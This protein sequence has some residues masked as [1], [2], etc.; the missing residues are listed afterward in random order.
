MKQ[1]TLQ[2]L[3]SAVLYVQKS[4]VAPVSLQNVS[5]E[6]FAKFDFGKDLHM[7]NIRVVNVLVE[8]QRVYNLDLPMAIFKKMPD[9]TVGSM[10]NAINA[11]LAKS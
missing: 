10:L 4:E 11:E 6:A 5:D 8:V 2:D 9:N 1:I 7:G 3:K